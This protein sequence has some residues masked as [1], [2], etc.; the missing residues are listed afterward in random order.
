MR[1]ND[2]PEDLIGTDDVTENNAMQYLAAIEQ[3]ASKIWAEIRGDD[4]EEQESHHGTSPSKHEE[5]IVRLMLPSTYNS[6][7]DNDERPFTMKEL[8]ESLQTLE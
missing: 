2:R 4:S 1:F 7:E 6:Q 3:K 5:K 8:Q